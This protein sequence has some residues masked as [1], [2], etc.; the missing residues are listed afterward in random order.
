MREILEN[1]LPGLGNFELCGTERERFNVQMTT[2]RKKSRR[3][4]IV[5]EGKRFQ[6]ELFFNFQKMR[7]K[8]DR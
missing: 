4:H 5:Q 1:P 8:C 6:E 2:E 3:L 7:L